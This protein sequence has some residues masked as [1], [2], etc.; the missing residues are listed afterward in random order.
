M[1]DFYTNLTIDTPENVDL[2]AEV[3][4]FGTRCLAA[5]LD[6]LILAIVIFVI[7]MLFF[8]AMFTP[9]RERENTTLVA[10]W[11]GLQFVIVTFY[12]LIF[13]FLWNGQ[14]P[15]KRWLN[16]RVVQG[17]GLPA[18]TTGLLI[19]NLVRLFDFFPVFY[20]V[21]LAVMFA[22]K[23][24]QRLGDLAAKTVVIRERK[25]LTLNAIRE[26]YAVVYH[27]INRNEPI[28]DYVKIDSLT[29][30]D[31]LDIVNYLQR[32]KDLSKREYIVGMLASRIAR[33]MGDETL[34]QQFRSPYAAE[35]FLE[36]IARAFELAALHENAP[37][38]NLPS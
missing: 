24:T 22:T 16:I 12:H 21:G 25:S 29:E 6:Y 17:N 34:E 19:R 7:T 8:Q 26:N 2:D 28:P 20:G 3:A 37:Q 23:N 32:R 27:H 13:E 30:Q 9:F 11:V 31:R 4:G 33:Q 10:L 14:T 35:R 36:Q 38:I 5:M 18:T 15:G 1:S